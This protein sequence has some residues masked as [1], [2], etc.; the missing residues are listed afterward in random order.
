MTAVEASVSEQ[1]GLNFDI[2]E[3]ECLYR[4]CSIYR[5]WPTSQKPIFIAEKFSESDC[6][7]LLVF[8]D[9]YEDSVSKLLSD[10]RQI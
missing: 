1:T 7:S 3:I 10:I 8:L 5:N 9:F 6:W 2:D 4:P